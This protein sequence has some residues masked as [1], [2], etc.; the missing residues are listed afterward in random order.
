MQIKTK[1]VFLAIA[2]V[3]IVS[4]CAKRIQPESEQTIEGTLLAGMG[5]SVGIADVKIVE[6]ILDK[7]NDPQRWISVHGSEII[8]IPATA[9]YNTSVNQW[10]RQVTIRIDKK[11]DILMEACRGKDGWIANKKDTVIKTFKII[12]LS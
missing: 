10:C 2:T 6:T 11:R 12:D 5:S 3:F 4:S 1:L 8:V 9:Y 7:L